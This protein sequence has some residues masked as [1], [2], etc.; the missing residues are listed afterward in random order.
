MMQNAGL[1]ELGQKHV[2]SVNYLIFFDSSQKS[3]VSLG[4]LLFV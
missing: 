2:K 1:T 4:F 3:Y